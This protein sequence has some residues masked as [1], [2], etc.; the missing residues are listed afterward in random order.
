MRKAL[1]ELGSLLHAAQ[2]HRGWLTPLS[3]TGYLK[4]WMANVQA[5]CPGIKDDIQAQ[6]ATEAGRKEFRRYIHDCQS[7]LVGL[8]DILYS[9]KPDKSKEELVQQHAAVSYA[10]DNMLRYLRTSYPDSFNPYGKV[11]SAVREVIKT[12]LFFRWHRLEEALIPL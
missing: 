2:S 6:T 8:S 11:P 4:E 5:G 3:D 12:D 10:V 7:L 1:T 9:I